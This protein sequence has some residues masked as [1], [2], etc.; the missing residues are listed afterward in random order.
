VAFKIKSDSK[1]F[2]SELFKDHCVFP[3]ADRNSD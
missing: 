3:P 1:N 2:I